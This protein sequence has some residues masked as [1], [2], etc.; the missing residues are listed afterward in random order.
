MKYSQYGL[1]LTEKFEGVKLPAYLDQVGVPTIGYG[2]TR[3]VKLGDVCTQQQAEQWLMED[4]QACELCVNHRVTVPLT[5][6]EFDALV[7]FCFNLG[8]GALTGSTLLRKLNSSDFSEAAGEFEKWAHA[9]GK[10]VAGLL[11]R[12]LEEE[13]EFNG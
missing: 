4:I 6:G 9:G 8:C 7:D 3:G 13:N 1:Q 11:R 10:V 12:R 2:H 5:Q